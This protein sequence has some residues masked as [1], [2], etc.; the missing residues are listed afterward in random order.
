MMITTH[1]P[2][3]LAVLAACAVVVV[4]HL[5]GLLL[6]RGKTGSTAS[7][8]GGQLR[9]AAIFYAGLLVAAAALVS[10]IGYW[11]GRYIWVRGGPARGTSQVHAR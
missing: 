10:P 6:T 2:A 4:V 8:G 7:R 5:T 3:S 11:S 1:W 9:E